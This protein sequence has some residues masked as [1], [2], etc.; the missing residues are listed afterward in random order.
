VS[1]VQL[2]RQTKDIDFDS[3]RKWSKLHV[4]FDEINQWIFF[5]GKLSANQPLTF[6][7]PLSSDEQLSVDDLFNLQM[8]LSSA[9]KFNPEESIQR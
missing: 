7:L 5:L 4:Y 3:G 1:D 8:K 9:L 2:S 6:V